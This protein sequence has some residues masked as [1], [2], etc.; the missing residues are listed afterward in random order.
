M[1]K[2]HSPPVTIHVN[3]EHGGLRAVVVLSLIIGAILGFAFIR[4]ILGIINDGFPDYTILASCIGSI[5]V[6]LITIW[7][8]ERILKRTWHSGQKIELDERGLTLVNRIE[9]DMV[10]KWQ[11]ELSDRHWTFGLSGFNRAARESRLPK[12][13]VCLSSMIQ[14]GEKRLVTF[15]YLPADKAELFINGTVGNLPFHSI[16]PLEVY[17]SN[18]RM[19]VGPTFH[20]AIP[21]SIL[22]GS[23]GRYWL[24]EKRRWESGFELSPKD[25]ET[26][27]TFVSQH[28]GTEIK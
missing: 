26:F 9:N 1:S 7:A 3:P 28:L 15:T 22:T 24:A 17:D 8:V 16:D 19:R 18:I 11:G 20:P 12:S 13:W 5:F 6:A 21:P 10:L 4:Q 23:N 2:M 14:D 25:Y 27:V